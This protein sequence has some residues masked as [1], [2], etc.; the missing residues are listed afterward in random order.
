MGRKERANQNG[1]RAPPQDGPLYFPSVA[2]LSLGSTAMMR[3]TK[4]RA[5]T[6]FIRIIR[7]KL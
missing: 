1:G 6:P 5:L 3:F 2:I 4:T 7:K